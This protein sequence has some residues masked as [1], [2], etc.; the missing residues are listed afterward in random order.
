MDNICQPLAVVKG[1][2]P[3]KYHI[4]LYSLIDI[5]VGA[6]ADGGQLHGP[7][8]LEHRAGG[9]GARIHRAGAAAGAA[10]LAAFVVIAGYFCTFVVIYF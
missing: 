2:Y 8:D 7:G 9:G 1:F 6:V 10:A 4:R 3:G 5:V